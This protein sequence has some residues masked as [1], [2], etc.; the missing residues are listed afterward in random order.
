MPVVAS[1]WR[2]VRDAGDYAN[3]CPQDPKQA[4]ILKGP[5]APQ[6][7]DCLYLNVWTQGCDAG[8]RAV[9]FYIHGGGYTTGS[10]HIGCLEGTPL[11]ARGDV[12]VVTINYRLGAFGFLN[13]RDAT[14]GKLP[15]TGAEGLADQIMALGWVRANI[16][17]FGGDPDNI[18]IFGESAGSG[19][20]CALLA[21]P[22]AK[23]MF[24][25]A[26]C[27][28]GGAHVGRKR[29][30]SAVTA[31]ALLERLGVAN[32]PQKALALPFDAILNA[33]IDLLANPPAGVAVNFGPTIDGDVLP[34]RAIDAI[35]AGSAAGVELI[36][37]T[38][39]DEARLFFLGNRKI[40]EM[41]AESLKKRIGGLAG[42]AAADAMITAYDEPTP[43]D[44]YS[45]IVGDNMF[46]MPTIRLLE[47]QST[48]ALSYGFRIDWKSPLLGGLL[49]ACHVIE[50]GFVFGTHK[51]PE[52]VDF[53]GDGPDAEALA[54]A[55]MD[56]WIG[57]AKVG[58]PGSRSNP[59]P[60]Y[61]AQTRAT[62]IFGDGPPHV[63]DDPARDRRLAW[64]A[65]SE[66]RFG[67]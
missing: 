49:G 17:A 43:A 3:L 30:E 56:S 67:L 33:Q 39:K 38:A 64:D 47:A 19:S 48:H 25:H 40:R 31:K 46:L 34:V 28:S 45:A 35:R 12:V 66:K 51:R 27:E 23:G 53:F 62:M 9:L 8:K 42:E 41:S 36:A 50:I 61:D 32:V 5:L 59:W 6:S 44:R 21:S 55:M 10:G 4:D 7:E 18:T 15:G 14:D 60:R 13:M 20:V 58:D 54:L 24:R 22:R 1:G 52:V 29:D 37:G 16:A 11:V 63:V 57:F 65:V 26:I 2:G